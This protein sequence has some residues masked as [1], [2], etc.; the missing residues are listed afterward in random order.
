MTARQ[1]RT[2]RPRPASEARPLTPEMVRLG[3]TQAGQGTFYPDRYRV[4]H[5]DDPF[6]AH[7]ITRGR[8]DV[9]ADLARPRPYQQDSLHPVA[10]QRAARRWYRAQLPE[11]TLRRRKIARYRTR[12]K[13]RLVWINP[14]PPPTRPNPPQQKKS[15][16]TMQP[17][18]A[19]D[20]TTYRF[21]TVRSK[22]FTCGEKGAK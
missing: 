14:C 15:A 1:E 3:F 7:M 12:P 19:L 8:D 11:R 20:R 21:I 6:F 2:A 16:T 13:L 22:G 17:A 10:W 9:L 5:P 18:D 4:L